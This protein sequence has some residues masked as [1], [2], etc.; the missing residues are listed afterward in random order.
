MRARAA[1]LTEVWGYAPGVSTR[2]LDTHV[3]SLRAMLGAAGALVE[4]V[5]G[6]GYRLSDE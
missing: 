4:T 5:R 3:K 1:L 6:M 2:T